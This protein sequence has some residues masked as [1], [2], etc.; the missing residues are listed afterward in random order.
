MPLLTQRGHLPIWD[1][2]PPPDP[3]DERDEMDY[4]D[5]QERKHDREDE[6]YWRK[7]N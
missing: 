1:D 7:G 2:E 6:R 3:A 4:E 5:E